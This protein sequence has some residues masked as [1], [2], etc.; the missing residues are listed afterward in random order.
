M[1]TQMDVDAGNISIIPHDVAVKYGINKVHLKNGLFESI[2]ASSSSITVTVPN[3]LNEDKE[4]SV[5]TEDGNLYYV[6]DACYIIKDWDKF[7][8]DTDC[9]EQMPEGCACINTGSDGVFTVI[10]D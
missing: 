9:L 2:R 6:G 7:I 3:C 5:V 8:E 4:V 10:I 1:K